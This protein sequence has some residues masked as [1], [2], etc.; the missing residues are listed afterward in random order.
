MRSAVSWALL[1][2]VI[3]RPGY[4]YELA[5]RFERTYQGVLALSSV[6]HVYSA[7][8]A[9]SSRSLV[10]EVPGSRDARQPKPRYAAT[11]AGLAQFEAWL[12]QQVRAERGRQRLLVLQLAALRR[13]P[14]ADRILDRF[15]QAWQWESDHNALAAG[16]A[17]HDSLTRLLR[18]ESRLTTEAKLSWIGHARR[19]LQRCVG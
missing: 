5:Q 17:G 6:S 12:I 4:A 1:A 19:E 3:E 16:D 13:R 11:A 7:I 9:L 14:D 2:L 18:E 10:E 8:D 15:E